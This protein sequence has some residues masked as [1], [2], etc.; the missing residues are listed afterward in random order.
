M[1]MRNNIPMEQPIP[2]E[3]TFIGSP[4][5]V[6]LHSSHGKGNPTVTSKMFDPME[7]ETA[8]SPCPCLATRTDVMR[9]G[10]EVPAARIVKPITASEMPTTFPK[11]VAHH[12]IKYENPAIHKMLPKNVIIKNFFFSGFSISGRVSQSGNTRGKETT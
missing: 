10:T 1:S 8:I 6:M 7:D 9:S 5:W 3:L 12:T 4:P 2:T 11:M